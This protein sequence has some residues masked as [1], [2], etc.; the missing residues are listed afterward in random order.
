M[1]RY[2]VHISGAKKL[3]EAV[4]LA[5]A[6]QVSKTYGTERVAQCEE[7]I[8]FLLND[9]TPFHRLLDVDREF[10]ALI[11]R[12]D[13]SRRDSR[14]DSRTKW[15]ARRTTHPPEARTRAQHDARRRCKGR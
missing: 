7:A 12:T 8:E 6:R 1:T 15:S 4:I 14:Q 3:A 13:Q 11:V 9:L 2:T 5:A 10:M